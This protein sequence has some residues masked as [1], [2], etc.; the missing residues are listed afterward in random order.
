MSNDNTD[1][2][3]GNKRTEI[4]LKS[5][6]VPIK[7]KAK[8]LPVSKPN[9]YIKFTNSDMGKD[10][11]Q[12]TVPYIDAQDVANSPPVPLDGM[13]IFLKGQDGYGGFLAPRIKTFDYGPYVQATETPKES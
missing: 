5:P 7:A 6:D 1:L 2:T 8:S 12:S 13:G 3:K 10:A 9:T 4:F 11:A